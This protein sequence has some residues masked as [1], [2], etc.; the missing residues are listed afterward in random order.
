MGTLNFCVEA[1]V[2]AVGGEDDA[3]AR[4]HHPLQLAL[5]HRLASAG[6]GGR[7]A[8]LPRR[9]GADRLHGDQG[10]LARHR[11]QGAVLDRHG[12]RL[13]GG[14]DLPRREAVPPRRARRR[15]LP[16]GDSPTRAC[17]RWSPATSTREVVGVPDGRRG[18]RPARRAL[19]ARALLGARSSACSTTARPVVRDYFE[20]HPRRPL[21]RQ[22]RDGR[23]RR[24]RRARAVRGGG[25]GQTARQCAST[26]RTRPTSSPGPINCPL[27]STVSASRVA[28]T[29]LAGGERGAERGALP[30]DRGRDAGPARCSTRSRRRRASSTAGR[31]FRR[32]RR[33]T[34]PSRRRCRARCRPAAAATSARYVWW[35]VRE[36]TGEPWADGS[37]HPV[38]QGAHRRRRRRQARSST[39]RGGDA[40]LA[41]RGLGGARTPGCSSRSSSDRTRAGRASTAAGSASTC[42]SRCSRTPTSP[43]WSSGRRPRRGGSR[44]A[45]RR[46]RTPA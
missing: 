12:R 7:D 23:Q 10:P 36:G 42:S 32:S 43:P 31:R 20:K 22:R 21:R 40:L 3:R 38:G 27:P 18:A 25:R 29:M 44:A 2:E 46:C 5:R 41:A 28:I 24:R 33:S 1:A 16:D 17:R 35:G 19:R 45:A 26:T 34:T 14:H 15:H 8:G 9:R 37:P 6:R 11:R 4:R 13:P 39:R 30:A